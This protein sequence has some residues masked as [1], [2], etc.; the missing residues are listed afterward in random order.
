M[1]QSADRLAEYA[2]KLFEEIPGGDRDIGHKKAM[3]VVYMA[4]HM[5]LSMYKGDES[6]LDIMDEVHLLLESYT[7]TNG[8]A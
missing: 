8:D 4:G 5:L 3:M 6:L 7:Q 2:L 1:I